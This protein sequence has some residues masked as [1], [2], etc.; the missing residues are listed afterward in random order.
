VSLSVGVHA[1]TQSDQQPRDL[2]LGH[3]DL[4]GDLLLGHVADE[5]HGDDAPFPL[6]QR[7]KPPT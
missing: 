6:G 2:H 4:F 5:P 3:P 1:V 7:S